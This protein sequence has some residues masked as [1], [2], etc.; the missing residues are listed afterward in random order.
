MDKIDGDREEASIGLNAILK[1]SLNKDQVWILS[2]AD[3]ELNTAQLNE[4]DS[5]LKR[6]IDHEPLPYLLGEVEFYG[7]AFR[8]SPAVLIPRPE[9]ELLVEEVLAWMRQAERKERL[10]LLDIGTGSGCIPISIMKI[11]AD[12]RG[13]AVDI[14]REAL[15]VAQQNLVR[16]GLKDLDLVQG[17]LI[18]AL[19]GKF[20]VVTANLP[21]IPSQELNK[22]RVAKHE[23]HLAL[24]GGPDGLFFYR[25]LFASLPAVVAAPAICIFEI[26]HDQGLQIQEVA[27]RYFQGKTV[28]IKKDYAGF[29]RFLKIEV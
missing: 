20:N 13:V 7:T 8:V 12:C 25:R 19:D 9:T 23:P 22:L 24:D 26:H 4:L 14:S 11:V 15:K 16:N 5:H 29:D 2:H 3:Y 6:L 27:A 1:K 21:Y 28:E 10:R 17:D 18:T